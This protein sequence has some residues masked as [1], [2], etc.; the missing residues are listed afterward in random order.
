MLGG[1]G[2]VAIVL[3][4]LHH[5]VLVKSDTSDVALV[6]RDIVWARAWMRP[7]GADRRDSLAVC[8]MA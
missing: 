8:L 2:S 3:F 6:I 4:I 5:F 7:R 1:G